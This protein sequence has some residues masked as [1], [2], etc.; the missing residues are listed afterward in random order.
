MQHK[1][2]GLHPRNLH[3]RPYDFEK[4]VAVEP[5]LQHYL[6]PRK[7]GQ[8]SVDFSNP[9]AVITLNRALLKYFYDLK[10]W[11]VPPGYLTPPI[12]GRVDYLHYLADLLENDVSHCRSKQIRALDIGTGANC[13]YALLGWKVYGWHFVAT[14]IERVSIDSA[15][16]ILEKNGIDKKS[17]EL[18]LQSHSSHIFKGVIQKGDCFDVTLCNP[19]FHKSQEAA[20]KGSHRKVKNLTKNSRAKLKLNFQGQSNE[21][22]Y[23]GGEIAFI[24]KM[25]EE[26]A[27]F[28]KEVGWFT[29]LVSKKENLTVIYRLLKRVKVSDIKT[30]PMQQGQ[31]LT[32]IV[33]WKFGD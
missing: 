27:L 4:L 13:I 18:R 26:S 3:N 17:I 7:D 10:W 15:Q 20:S 29:T 23:P 8:L 19:P 32:R 5:Q 12:P 1:P 24:A 28:Q 6:A 25:I 31:K 11:S 30:I 33:A 14:D 9:D 2:K 22:W 21:L 16:K